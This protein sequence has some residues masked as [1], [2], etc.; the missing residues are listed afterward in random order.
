MKIIKLLIILSVLL[1]AGT[2]VERRPSGIETLLQPKVIMIDDYAEPKQTS[3][4]N[5][6]ASR[7]DGSNGVGPWYA[8]TATPQPY[9]EP[10][11]AP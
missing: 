5:P 2:P 6:P 8:P 3:E 10:Y 7:G 1:I 9:P 11:P 4:D